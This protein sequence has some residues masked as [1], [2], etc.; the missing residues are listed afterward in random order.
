VKCLGFG[1]FSVDCNVHNFHQFVMFTVGDR[2]DEFTVEIHHGGFFVGSGS[3]RSYVD[4]SVSW[5][6]CIEADT[7]RYSLRSFVVFGLCRAVRLS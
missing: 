1:G 5:F 7:F 4:E 6:E 2:R 3:L